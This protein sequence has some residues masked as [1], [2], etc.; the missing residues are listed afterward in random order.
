LIQD[1]LIAACHDVVKVYEMEDYHLVQTNY[2]HHDSIR[3]LIFIPERNH[4][5]SVSWDR[6]IRVWKSYRKQSYQKKNVEEENNKKFE[7]WVW[8][9]MKKAMKQE[10]SFDLTTYA[11]RL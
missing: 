9:Q 8:N 11:D 7:T 5:V 2:G 6:T 10:R 4:I 3:D 1:V